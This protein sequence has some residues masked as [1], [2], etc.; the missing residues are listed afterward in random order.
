MFYD[1]T[2]WGTL[3]FTEKR[4]DAPTIGT[5]SAGIT[6]ATV[7]FTAPSSDGGSAIT[8]YTATSSPGDFT[9]TISQ[10]GS[11]SIIV[12]GLTSGTAYTFTVTATNAM[13]TSLASAVS[14]SVVTPQPQLGDFY[15]GGVVFKLFH[16]GQI[17]YVEG[18]THGLIA[19]VQDQRSGIRWYTGDYVTTGATGIVVGTGSANTDAIISVQGPTETSYA[20]G[21]ARANTGGGYTDWFLPSKAELNKMWLERETINTTASANG[22]SNFSSNWYW[23]ST[24]SGSS[25]AWIHHLSDGG[26]QVLDKSYSVW[27][28]AVRAF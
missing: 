12:S 20:A 3:S 13:G 5:A 24:E 15:G 25:Y 21:L 1:G 4:P 26:T 10:S 19:A 7:P 2:E 17:G 8:S 18:E 23:S 6:V 22:G 14:N 9:G 11:G 27:V 28:R 16:A